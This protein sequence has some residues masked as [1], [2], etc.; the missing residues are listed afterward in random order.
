MKVLKSISMIALIVI[1]VFS[2]HAQKMPDPVGTWKFYAE[3]APYEYNT[4]DIV[5][6][7]EGEEYTAKIVFGEYYEIKAQDFLFE[8]DQISFKAYIEDDVIYIKGTVTED[9]LD[10]KA[11]YSEG[12]IGFKSKRKKS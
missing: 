12:T 3:E 9:S 1:T 10:G 8:G 11:S 2:V 7:K 6:E 4:G 5:I